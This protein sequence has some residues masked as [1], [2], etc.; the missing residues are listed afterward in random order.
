MKKIREKLR[1]QNGASILLALLFFL[2]CGMVGA[3]VL[4]AAASNAGK[5]R[6][7]REE[8]QKY[9]TLSSA[10]Q[11]VCDEL[12][13]ASYIGKYNVEKRTVQYEDPVTNEETEYT[14]MVISQQQGDFVS[15]LGNTLPVRDALDDLFSRQFIKTTGGGYQDDHIYEPLNPFPTWEHT[16]TLNVDGQTDPGLGEQVTVKVK[17]GQSVTEQYRFF[18]TAT[19]DSDPDYAMSTELT[20]SGIPKPDSIGSEGERTIAVKWTT[21]QIKRGADT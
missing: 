18:L 11:L 15:G 20:P 3:S 9:L 10:L 12:E 19:L 17:L 8:Q 21:G 2:L 6:S 7:S 16:L 4:M 14:Y 13:S 1:S 5:S